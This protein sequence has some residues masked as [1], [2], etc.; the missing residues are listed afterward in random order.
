M[1]TGEKSSYTGK[2]KRMAA[3]IE[4]SYGARG[5]P[6]D[7]A[8]ARAWATVN[9]LSGGGKKS[10][11]GRAKTVTPTEKSIRKN[12]S[13]KSKRIKELPLC[14]YLVPGKNRGQGDI[15]EKYRPT[16]LCVLGISTVFQLHHRYRHCAAGYWFGRILRR[17]CL[18]SGLPGQAEQ[19]AFQ[20]VANV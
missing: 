9:K 20:G 12:K 7:E 13:E 18:S 3:H 2:Q 10:G 19:Q 11:S 17:G 16:N 5:V 1:P 14:L 4:D 15:A 8:E 6:K